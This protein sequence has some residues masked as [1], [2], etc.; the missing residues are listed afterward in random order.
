MNEV[1]SQNNDRDNASDEEIDLREISKVLW[2]GKSLIASITVLGAVISVVT[3]LM[4]TNIYRSESILQPRDSEALGGLSQFSG[5]ASMAGISLPSS[6]G[7]STVE[8]IEIIKSRQ[9]VKHLITFDEVLPSL[10]AAER[11]DALSR[12]LIFN[13]EIYDQ[14]SGTWLKGPTADKDKP[15]F[16]D[17]HITYTKMVEI[18][19]DNKTGLVSINVEHISPVFAKEFLDL[20]ISEANGWKR[21]KDMTST[22]EALTFLNEELSRTPVAPIRES[23]NQLI[24]GQLEKRMMAQ[25][26][27]DYA[28]TVIEPPFIPEMKFFPVRSVISI[29]G[30]L[31]A[32]LLSIVIVLTRNYLYEKT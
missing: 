1:K 20:I 6:T 7:G 22:D 26:H 27:E 21:N 17:A 10:V 18:A 30:T 32:L 19:Q 5:L 8:I 29:L 9:F 12:K 3:S 28:L 25:I 4:L 2:G 23:I 15:S 16:I 24:E 13:D 31:G 11:Y 14:D